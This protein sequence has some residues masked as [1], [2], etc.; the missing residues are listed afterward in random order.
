MWMSQLEIKT[1]LL[2]LLAIGQDKRSNIS[3]I[4]SGEGGRPAPGVTILG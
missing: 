4:A 1:S 2:Y 3:G